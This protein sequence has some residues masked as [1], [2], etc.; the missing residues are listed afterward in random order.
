MDPGDSAFFAW[1]MA[2]GRTPWHT[3]RPC[4]RT[5]T[6]SIPTATPWAWTSRSWARPSW[7]CPCRP[8]PT[9]RSWC[10]TSSRLLT[11]VL[12][13]LTA[14]LLARDLGCG[15]AA[16]L[17]AGAAFAFSPIRTDQIAHLSTLGTQWLPLVLLFTFRFFRTGLVRDALL[18][19]LFFALRGLRLRLSRHHRPHGPAPGR[20]ARSSG[21]GGAAARGA[22]RR[23]WRRAS[24]C[25]RSIG[26]RAPRSDQLG[27]ARGREETIFYAAAA[28]ELPR[29]LVLEPRLRRADRALPPP[30][31]NNLFPGLVLPAIV[32]ARGLVAGASQGGARA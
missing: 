14:Y 8:S 27:F 25:C 22:G 29:H 28:G 12:T 5:P 3:A 4:C 30:G 2:W 13:G 23:P 31:P 15:E 32:A 19:A 20:A 26:C 24:R 17:F 1:V 10:S 9:T 21:D 16:A 7:P 6:S 11:F 18:A